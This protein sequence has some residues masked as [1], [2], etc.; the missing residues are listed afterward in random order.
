M[1]EDIPPKAQ[2]AEYERNRIRSR[3]FNDRHTNGIIDCLYIT[4]FS[5]HGS[6]DIIRKDEG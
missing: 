4:L 2:D 1:V 3:S 6:E 5:P